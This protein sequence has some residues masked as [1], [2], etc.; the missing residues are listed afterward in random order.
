MNK[1]QSLADRISTLLSTTPASFDPED[2]INEET[3]KVTEGALEDDD[4]TE[5]VI[6]SRF[7][8][9]NVEILEDV[10]AK[11]SGKKGNRKNFK[12]SDEEFDTESEIGHDSGSG[13]DDVDEEEDSGENDE[14]EEDYNSD[15]G[16]DDKDESEDEEGIS[17]DGDDHN[18]KH[19]KEENVSGQLKKGLCIRTQLN[20][21]ENLLEMRIQ[22]QKCLVASNKM[23]QKE[24]YNQILE[25]TDFKKKVNETKNSLSNTL[26]KL[27]E[28]QSLVWKKY[29]DTKNLLKPAKSAS[30]SEESDEEIPSDSDVES[31]TN[32]SEDEIKP[33]KKRVKLLDYEKILDERHKNYQD[34]RNSTIQ[35]W[36]DKTIIGSKS[37]LQ[38]S[39]LNQINH[40]LTDRS[41]LIKRTQTKRS[42]YEII[43]EKDSEQTENEKSDEEKQQELNPEIFDDDDFYHQLLRELIEVKSA[44]LTDPVQLGRQW[45][46]LQNL[47]SK[48]KRKIDTRATKGRKIRYTVHSKL[49]NFMAPIDEGSYT[50]EAKVELFSSIC[51]KNEIVHKS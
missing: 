38:H 19:I 12:E 1:S 51:G 26:N 33:P 32:E 22:M 34:Y 6:L 41:R 14:N 42:N 5:D 7:R 25:H 4:D 23:P 9:K 35:K 18:F 10:D 47:R 30:K 45:I 15:D 3:A 27:L 44:D 43:G 2:E 24:T 13:D 28:L 37:D 20:I 29:P 16:E 40:I 21:W 48:M 39:V 49:V 11:Y 36:N 50:E 17:I 46:Q 31:D 8:K